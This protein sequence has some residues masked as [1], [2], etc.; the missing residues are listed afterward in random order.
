MSHVQTVTLP[1]RSPSR[2]GLNLLELLL[3]FL[4]LDIQLFTF[5]S[6]SRVFARKL[7]LFI[8]GHSSRALLVRVREEGQFVEFLLDVLLRSISD[9]SNPMVRGFFGSFLDFDGRL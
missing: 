6:P 1:Y 5:L 3:K 4:I 9:R 7:K 2:S 8:H